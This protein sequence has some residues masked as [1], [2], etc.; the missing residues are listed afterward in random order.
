MVRVGTRGRIVDI[1][2]HRAAA[3]FDGARARVLQRLYHPEGVVIELLDDSPAEDARRYWRRGMTGEI[4]LRYFV[5]DQRR[6]GTR[7]RAGA[8]MK[9]NEMGDVLTEAD[10]R[11]AAKFDV[12][13]FGLTMDEA[14]KLVKADRYPGLLKTI[15]D[16]RARHGWPAANSALTRGYI[17]ELLGMQRGRP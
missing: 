14:M 4:P 10:Y 1:D 12:K 11:Q 16:W 7:A 2:G 5:P 3:L 6:S 17:Y 15:E 13:R 8:R 9:R